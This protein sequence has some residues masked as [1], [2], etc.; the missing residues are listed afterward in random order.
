MDVQRPRRSRP[1]LRCKEL[2]QRMWIALFWSWSHDRRLWRPQHHLDGLSLVWAPG[3]RH[4]LN[5]GYTGL[6]RHER[7]RRQ[8][9]KDSAAGLWGELG[10]S[11][12]RDSGRSL[13][14]GLFC[15][16][17]SWHLWLSASCSVGVATRVS[18]CIPK[19]CCGRRG[20]LETVVYMGFPALHAATTLGF[21]IPSFERV[22]TLLSFAFRI[23][24]DFVSPRIYHEEMSRCVVLRINLILGL[25]ALGASPHINGPHFAIHPF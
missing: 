24:P 1:E 13:L 16:L 8:G 12:R 18:D 2:T 3:R 19:G 5:G 23:R 10:S 6:P 25:G 21:S 11:F 7:R 15:I 14:P 20:K 9:A 22:S 4:L 17:A